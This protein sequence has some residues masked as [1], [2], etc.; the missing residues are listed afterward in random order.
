MI[1]KDQKTFAE[2]VA[3][4]LHSSRCF[5]ARSAQ[6]PPYMPWRH[7]HSTK[8]KAWSKPYFPS[9]NTSSREGVAPPV[10]SDIRVVLCSLRHSRLGLPEK[11]EVPID[12]LNKQNQE[13]M[14]RS[15]VEWPRKISH[16][17]LPFP[18]LEE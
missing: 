15:M 4:S 14:L 10:S 2:G 6:V 8:S 18:H 11:A 12:I 16:G 5:D 9:L 3:V 1:I 17:S 13:M 7:S